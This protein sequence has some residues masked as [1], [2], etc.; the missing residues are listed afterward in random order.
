MPAIAPARSFV[1]AAL[2]VADF[3][4]LEPLYRSLLERPLVVAADVEA[5]LDDVSELTAVVDEYGSRRSID[6]SCHTDDPEAERRFLHFVEQV[7]PKVKPL[8]FALQKKLL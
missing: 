8:F 7:E 4:Q 2:D 6:K 5:W 1:P 3:S